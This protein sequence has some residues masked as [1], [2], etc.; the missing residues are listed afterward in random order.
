VAQ[1]LRDQYAANVANLLLARASTRRKEVAIRTALGAGRHD[2]VRMVIG[3]GL[4]L[5]TIGALVGA[6]AALPVTRLMAGLLYEVNPADPVTFTAVALLLL[7][8]ASAA[9][10][11]P[12]RRAVRVDPVT[13]LRAE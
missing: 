12:A 11:L 3:Q 9:S 5:A 8:V 2:V 6:A 7:L 4:T 1:H 10:W 13:A